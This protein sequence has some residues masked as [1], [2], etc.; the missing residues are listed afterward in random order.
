MLGTTD[1]FQ[2]FVA[3]LTFWIG[4]VASIAAAYLMVVSIKNMIR[5]ALALTTVLGGVATMYALLG[6]D[7]LAAAQLVVYVGAIMVLII[8]AIFMTPGQ[9]DVPG[10]V[11]SRQRLGAMLVSLGVGVISI[12]VV[13]REPWKERTTLLDLPTAESI[14]GLMLTRYVLPFEIASILLTVAL[15]GA[16]V[17]AREE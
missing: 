13:I 9:I 4:A 10:L 15:I 2:T 14:G 16:I 7:F 1:P 17:I 5:A 8:F 3:T 6:A 12:W 11:G